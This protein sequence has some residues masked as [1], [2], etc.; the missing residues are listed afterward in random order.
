MTVEFECEIGLLCSCETANPWFKPVVLILIMPLFDFFFVRVY[1]VTCVCNSTWMYA[2]VN[3]RTSSGCTCSS[4][5]MSTRPQVH[6]MPQ[7]RTCGTD[8]CGSPVPLLALLF[9]HPGGKGGGT[10]VLMVDYHRQHKHRLAL[11]QFFEG[12]LYLLCVWIKA[13]GAGERV[14]PSM[15]FLPWGRRVIT[16][17]RTED[18]KS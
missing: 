7:M 3:I 8:A 14:L 11:S 1:I 5:C 10:S 9:P 18:K 17:E 15:E 12:G 16:W 2:T 13:R 4:R 6:A